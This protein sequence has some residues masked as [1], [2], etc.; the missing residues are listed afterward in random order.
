M[1]R[2]SDQRMLLAM[3]KRIGAKIIEVKAS[4]AVFMTLP[5]VV[6]DVIEQAARGAARVAR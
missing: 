3:A 2:L 4:H 5:K 6:T 1:T